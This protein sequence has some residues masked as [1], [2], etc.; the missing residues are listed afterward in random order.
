MKIPKSKQ[1]KATKDKTSKEGK[2]GRKRA[3]KRK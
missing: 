3:S 2:N 1:K